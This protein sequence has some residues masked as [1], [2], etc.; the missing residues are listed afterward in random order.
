MT[1]VM[2]VS[3]LATAFLFG[4]VFYI[5]D[6]DVPIC[7]NTCHISSGLW[8]HF[9]FVYI[10]NYVLLRLVLRLVVVYVWILYILEE[11]GRAGRFG[12]VY[13]YVYWF[14]WSLVGLYANM[15]EMSGVRQIDGSCPFF[16]RNWK[17]IFKYKMCF[18]K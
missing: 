11:I 15:A 6:T 9:F 10:L 2:V 18:N 1:W 5:L 14:D 16:C 4:S 17:T 3:S 12:M 8:L 7:G 13:L